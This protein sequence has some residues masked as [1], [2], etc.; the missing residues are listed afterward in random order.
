MRQN[1]VPTPIVDR[2]GKRTT[3]HRGAQQQGGQAHGALA[4]VA[5]TVTRPQQRATVS[6]VSWDL[7]SVGAPYGKD[8][9]LDSESFLARAGLEREAIAAAAGGKVSVSVPV[10][11]LFEYLRVGIGPM[12]A[13]ALET[14]GSLAKWQQDPGF[15]GALPGSLARRTRRRGEPDF[16]VGI[17]DAVDRMDAAG[18]TPLKAQALLANGLSDDHFQRTELT[19]EQVFAIFDRFKYQ[20]STV[21]AETNAAAT[22]DAILDGRLPWRAVDK[23]LG[24]RRVALAR[25]VDLVYPETWARGSMEVESLSP[26]DRDWL[27]ED[28]DRLLGLG[29]LLSSDHRN[30][31][32]EGV[33]TDSIAA[34]RAYGAEACTKA[35]AALLL[36]ERSDGRPF[37]PDGANAALEFARAFKEA[38]GR[39]LNVSGAEA[40]YSNFP[41]SDGYRSHTVHFADIV[42]AMDAGFDAE[43]IVGLLKEGC[44]AAQ[45]RAIAVDGIATA[46]TRGAL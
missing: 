17:G 19:D 31:H 42:E 6:K 29:S 27:L 11:T 10:P 40:S 25:V 45:V 26:L 3:V 16:I 20:P 30:Y 18:L 15:N 1:L 28:P 37:G 4:A 22:I 2:N 9:E 36:A 13:A 21:G 8:N 12:E 32:V 33:L 23:E 24:I 38:A 7:R 43:H 39:D 35:P 44:T 34:L 14:I 5:P 41:R 46:L